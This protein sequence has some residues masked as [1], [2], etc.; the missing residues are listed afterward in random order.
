MNTD[1]S[2]SPLAYLCASVFIRGFFSPLCFSSLCP[3]CLCGPASFASAKTPMLL[4]RY[5]T[6]HATNGSMSKASMTPSPFASP[7]QGAH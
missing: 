5:G 1:K 3:L 6:R 7:V 4:V 2:D